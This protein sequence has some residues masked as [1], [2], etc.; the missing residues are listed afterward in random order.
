MTKGTGTSPTIAAAKHQAK[1]I[2][3][4]LEQHSSTELSH[5]EALDIVARLN[6]AKNWNTFRFLNVDAAPQED[7]DLLPAK[8]TWW[9]LADE[10]NPSE[11]T[12]AI[13]ESESNPVL[14][15][16]LAVRI[17]VILSAAAKAGIAAQL[18]K[19]LSELFAETS[20]ES[21][22]SEQQSRNGKRKS[23]LSCLI[24]PPRLM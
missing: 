4:L 15:F 8:I 20:K 17:G 19:V 11:Q 12:R 2:R 9:L 24:G 18:G 3:K 1:L 21:L 22:P 10:V 13:Y 23:K 7:F 14:P 6:G 16:K 5:C